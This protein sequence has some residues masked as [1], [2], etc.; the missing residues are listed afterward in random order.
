MGAQ[1]KETPDKS[2]R[3]IAEALNVDYKTV[4]AVSKG[5]ERRGAIP[6]VDDFIDSLGC[7]QPRQREYQFIDDTPEGQH[8]ILSRAREIKAWRSPFR[9]G[10]RH[11]RAGCG[12]TLRVPSISLISQNSDQLRVSD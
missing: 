5:S 7:R 1:L 11:F 12:E 6:H 3:Q 4:G 2:D 10:E 9:Y 8:A